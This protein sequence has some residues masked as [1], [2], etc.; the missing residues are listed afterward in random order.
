MTK[1]AYWKPNATRQD[2][3]NMLRKV[4]R[5]VQTPTQY[6]QEESST[7]IIIDI[8]DISIILSIA[9]SI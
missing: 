1:E 4:L 7:I 3:Y 6:A 8:V 2:T 9:G 5:V